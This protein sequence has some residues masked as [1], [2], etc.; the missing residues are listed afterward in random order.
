MNLADAIRKASERTAVPEPGPVPS[1]EDAELHS[2]SV[3]GFDTVAPVEAPHSAV[4]SGNV[5]R[6]ELFL[7]PEQMSG[8]LK[9]ILVGQHTVMTLREAAAYLRVNPSALEKLA[10]DGTIPAVRIEGRWRFP[11]PHLDEWMVQRATAPEVDDNAA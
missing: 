10:E 4:L 6:L 11:K 2:A 3:A 8:M 5:V 9:A 7:T 1:L